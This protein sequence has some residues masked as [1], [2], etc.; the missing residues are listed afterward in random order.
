MA[1]IDMRKGK[2]DKD[3]KKILQRQM[4]LFDELILKTGWD[5]DQIGLRLVLSTS[6]VRHAARGHNKLGPGSLA[7]LEE[8]CEMHRQQYPQGAVPH[9]VA[10]SKG[11]WTT[12]EVAGLVLDDE[13][14]E[15]AAKVA[16]GLGC[17][18]EEAVSLV[19]E[20]RAAQR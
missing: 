2:I 8:L 14:R 20:R 19:L 4:E 16:D 12:G 6:T 7:R 18:M 5:Y 11:V 1:E 3:G 13:L 17:T 9:V 10:E 15:S